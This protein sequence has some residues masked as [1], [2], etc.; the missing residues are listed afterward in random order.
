MNSSMNGIYVNLYLE[1]FKHIFIYNPIQN[2][3]KI[4][5]CRTAHS[6]IARYIRIF[7]IIDKITVFLVAQKKMLTLCVPSTLYR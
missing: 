5:I 4:N 3:S 7:T 6:K 1:Y 2:E